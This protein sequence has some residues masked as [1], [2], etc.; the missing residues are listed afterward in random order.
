MLTSFGIAEANAET[1]QAA[2]PESDGGA[3]WPDRLP[4][5]SPFCQELIGIFEATRN[6]TTGNESQVQ[7]L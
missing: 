1:D 2:I 4:P 3:R 6:S 7:K 5:F